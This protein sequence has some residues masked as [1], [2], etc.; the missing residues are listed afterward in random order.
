RRRGR[1][2]GAPNYSADDKEALLDCV[3]QLLPVGAK[4][5]EQLAVEFNVWAV[6]N[7]RPER[8]TK[9]L[10]AKFKA[11]LRT[12]KPTGDADCPPEIERAHELEYLI[13][14]KAETRDLDDDEDEDI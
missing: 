8:L 14:S 11:W 13:N 1:S 2:A 9:S 10:E 4:G 12:T 5:W 6:E 3:E 7:G